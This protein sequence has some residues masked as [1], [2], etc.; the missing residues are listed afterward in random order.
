MLALVADLDPLAARADGV[1]QGRVQVELCA[2][3]V[4]VS[5]LQFCALAHAALVG[6]KL[7]QHE[8]QERGF[9]T[10]VGANEAHFVTAQKC[11][12]EVFDEQLAAQA[13]ADMFELG[14]DLARGQTGVQLEPHGAQFIAP[15]RTLF[16]QFDEPS[17]AADAARASR[18]DTFAYPHFFVRQELVFT[19]SGQRFVFKLTFFGGLKGRKVTRVTAQ[20]AAVEFNDACGHSVDESAVVRDQDQGPRGTRLRAAPRHEQFLQPLD[21]SDVEVVGGLVEQ[22]HIGP[23]HQRLRQ[24]HALFLAARQTVDVQCRVE[25]QALHG[26]FH[27][28]LPGPAVQRFQLR[29]QRVQVFMRGMGFVAFTQR[30]GRGHTFSHR[31]KHRGARRKHGLLRHIH[32]AQTGG[33]LQDAVVGFF[34]P[35]QHFEQG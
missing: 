17:H 11:R 25:I 15:R 3:L 23:R 5:H 27:A 26:F 14:H 32:A 7:A 6:L 4:E 31:F 24:R 34:Q 16:T 18:F 30:T 28:L 8:L 19:G 13:Q 21:G 12:A 35:C 29:L 22:E 2:H 20:L 10:A 1:D 9:A 33:Q